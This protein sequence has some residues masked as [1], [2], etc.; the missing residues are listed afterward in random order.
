MKAKRTVTSWSDLVG[1]KVDVSGN[2]D[3]KYN[4]TFA[5]ENGGA[6]ETT[7]DFEHW[8]FTYG[9]PGGFEGVPQITL[10]FE[11]I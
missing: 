10:K 5:G 2:V 9:M 7:N 6:D 11:M 4:L 3:M 8:N 1:L